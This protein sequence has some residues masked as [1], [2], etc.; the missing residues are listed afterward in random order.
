[1]ESLKKEDNQTIVV[2]GMPGSGKTIVAIFLMKYLK[3][4]EEFREKKIGF[5]VPQTSLRKTL[6]GIFK[7]IYGLKAS[8][9]LS[10]SDVTKQYYDILLVDEA[11]R[12]HQYKNISYMGPFKACCERIGLTTENDELDW[13]L[14]QCKC[15]ILFYDEMQVVGPSGIDVQRF[16]R[17]MK[18]DQS[19][20]LLTYFNLLTQMRVR[21]GNDYISYV[22]ELLSGT[23]K[24]KK[25]FSNYD[26]KI[27][28]DFKKFNQLM[29]QKEKE[30]QLVRMAAGYA[31]DW[32]SK[33][34]KS[35]YDIEIQGIKK[36][37]N[38]CTEGWV[39]SKEAV[40]E[41]GCIHS[42]QGY[43]LNYGFIIMGNEIGY[44]T[45]KKRIIIRP[46][47]YFD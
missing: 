31:W 21:G 36:Q 37:W 47:E 8:D 15:P 5:V 18:K 9:I 44:D 25:N 45:D 13:I 39:L 42:T 29:Y 14:H 43:D 33:K 35:L 12:L 23:V 1:M 3:D 27:V 22:K 19:K 20:R 40:D 11:H 4:S 26:L 17:K 38:H 6:K 34:N 32:I 7:S 10:P 46:Q 24:E 2:N 16:R 28:T 30:V 41:V